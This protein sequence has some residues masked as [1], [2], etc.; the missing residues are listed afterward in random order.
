MAEKTLKTTPISVI[1]LAAVGAAAP[2]IGGQYPTEGLSL[3]PGTQAFFE[4]LLGGGQLALMTHLLLIAPCAGVLMI[5]ALRSRVIQL[6]TLRVLYWLFPTM[7]LMGCTLLWT[8]FAFVAWQSWVVWLAATLPLFAVCALAGR[9]QGPRILVWAVA[10]GCALA[11]AKGIGEYA[12]MRALDPGWRIFAD[13]TNPNELA[14][15]MLI[16]LFLSMG[17]MLTSARIPRLVAGAATVLCGL[18]LLLTQ[19]LGSELVGIVALP[20]FLALIGVW[21]AGKRVVLVLVPL[22]LVVALFAATRLSP[23]PGPAGSTPVVGKSA[24]AQAQSIAFRLNLW[25]GAMELSRRHPQGVGIGAY[26]YHSARPGLTTQTHLAH[27]T[28][29]QVAVE[30]GIAGGVL[31]VGF[32]VVWLREMLK[33]AKGLAPQ[34]NVL[35]AAVLCAVGCVLAHSIGDSDLYYPGMA[36]ITFLLMGVGLCL[37]ADGVAPEVMPASLRIAGSALGAVIIVTLGYFAFGEYLRA[38]LRG[39]AMAGDRAR[40]QA[41]TRTLTSVYPADGETWRFAAA[42]APESADPA[43]KLNFLRRAARITPSTSNLRALAIA[44]MDSNPA[45]A[46]APL[47]EALEWDPNNMPTLKLMVLA[48]ERVGRIEDATATARRLVAV[49]GTPYFQVRALPQLVPTE[50]FWAREWLAG[51]E[52]DVHKRIELLQAAVDGY[53]RYARTTVPQVRQADRTG[54]PIAG[55]SLEQARQT[56][57]RAREIALELASLYRTLGRSGD[58]GRA[59]A[60]A[61]EL[62]T[63]AT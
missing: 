48:Q 47:Q 51:R 12:Q 3:E 1:V 13:W 52:P 16:G 4:G 14:V 63:A 33:G 49:E 61:E 15:V 21:G 59:E 29:L 54:V 27:N 11:A 35:R 58:A 5:H 39:A 23:T 22:A 56:L 57:A 46:L 31:F 7:A 62:G 25:K 32:L 37:S 30:T 20:C 34:A 9:V 43:A 28:Y 6:P 55:E 53:L 38:S 10:M 44:Q 40:V 18:A 41:I 60:A 19:S 8:K 2:I 17:L 45:D 26:R 42:Y 50:T 24:E 36:V